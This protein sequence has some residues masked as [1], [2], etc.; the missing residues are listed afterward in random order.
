MHTEDGKNILKLR[1]S[2]FFPSIVLSYDKII[3]LLLIFHQT[4]LQPRA[5]QSYAVVSLIK[6]FV[7]GVKLVLLSYDCKAVLHTKGNYYSRVWNK[8]SPLN[9]RSLWKI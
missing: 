9:K 7:E 2:T 8:R 4:A 3:E 1:P 5:E 6:R